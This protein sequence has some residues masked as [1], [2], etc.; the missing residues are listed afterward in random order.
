MIGIQL[1]GQLGNQLFQIAF[2]RRASKILHQFYAIIDDK[3]YGCLAEKYFILKFHERRYFR[4]IVKRLFFLTP[5]KI[6][7]FSNWQKPGEILDSLEPGV[8]YAGFFQSEGFL[9][10]AERRNYFRIKRKYQ[11]VFLKKY[12]DLFK[13]HKVIIVH[14][15]LKDYLKIGTEELGG[16]GL[17]LPLEYYQHA[18]D[19]LELDDNT[20][21]L[22][23]SDD[24]QYVQQNLNLAVPFS[25]EENH[26]I[27]DFL[28]LKNANGLIISNSSFSWWGAYLNTNVDL[29]VIAP[30]FWL[31][32]KV[33]KTYPVDI[34]STSWS[35]APVNN[36]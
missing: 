29:K 13:G 27:I 12:G 36:N 22:V 32:Y 6:I 15:R 5:R 34:I 23:I 31:G 1:Q 3:S 19:Q 11:R 33:K 30:E 25:I 18:L 20:K 4:K 26:F 21:V 8:T 7:E 14:I 17:Q 2:I 9:D 10:N 28:L 35:I 24:I 16:K